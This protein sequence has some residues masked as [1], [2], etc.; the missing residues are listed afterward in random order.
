MYFHILHFHFHKVT[1]ISLSIPLVI[2]ESL[3]DDHFTNLNLK[4]EMQII[5]SDNESHHLLVI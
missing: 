5:Q 2:H 3:I 4:S 1:A